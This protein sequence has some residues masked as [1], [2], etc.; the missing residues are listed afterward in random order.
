LQRRVV[1]HLVFFARVT[2]S[3]SVFLS[4]SVSLAR[5]AENTKHTN[6]KRTTPKKKDDEFWKKKEHSLVVVTFVLLF[7][8]TN[9]T[10]L[11]FFLF[12][13]V[14]QQGVCSSLSSISVETTKIFPAFFDG[15]KKRAL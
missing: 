5:A 1:R 13:C 2:P 14:F 9:K 7:F 3:F 4:L 15:H 11:F 10:P 8:A 6:D 12:L